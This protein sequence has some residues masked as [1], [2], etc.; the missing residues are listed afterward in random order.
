MCQLLFLILLFCFLQDDLLEVRTQCDVQI[1]T[2]KLEIKKLKTQLRALCDN[3]SLTDVF[4]TFEDNVARLVRENEALRQANLALEAKELDSL[5]RT[6]ANSSSTSDVHAFVNAPTNDGTN[7][8]YRLQ[9][10]KKEN[11]R[12]VT[13]LKKCASSGKR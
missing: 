4:A 11:L 3:Q 2:Y 8:S 9:T 10:A 13:K 5:L 7:E 1:D 6:G 12:L